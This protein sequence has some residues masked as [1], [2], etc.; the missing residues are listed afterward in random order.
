MAL[1]ATAA[2]ATAAVKAT[3]SKIS[4]PELFVGFR[5]KFKAFY[6]QIRLKI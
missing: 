5:F 1:I 3:V 4:K 2:T 6:T